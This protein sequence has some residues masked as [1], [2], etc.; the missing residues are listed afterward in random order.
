[1]A[2]SVWEAARGKHRPPV[3][4]CRVTAGE[5]VAFD[6][7]WV[8]VRFR[9]ADDARWFVGLVQTLY[10]R[11]AFLGP[12]GHRRVEPDVR[13][14]GRLN[15][16]CAAFAGDLYAHAE[17]LDGPRRGGVWYC[18]VSRGGSYLFHTADRG[19]VPRDGEAARWL[20]EVIIA[21]ARAGAWDQLGAVERPTVTTADPRG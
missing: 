20:C 16:D 17:H 15:D 14:G 2:V 10:N 18:S 9:T 7:S 19:V 13:W 12:P 4:A 6:S 1:M 8:S 3:W 5:A 11:G 21:A